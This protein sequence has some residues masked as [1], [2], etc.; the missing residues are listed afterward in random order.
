ME[1]VNKYLIIKK[2]L[3]VVK[4]IGRDESNSLYQVEWIY[5]KKY[6]YLRKCDMVSEDFLYDPIETTKDTW[7]KDIIKVS[8]SE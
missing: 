3:I 5:T 6:E 4:I 1:N 8:L 7:E 2:P